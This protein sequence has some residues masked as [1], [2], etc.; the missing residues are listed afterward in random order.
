MPIL[1]H[2]GVVETMTAIPISSK[3]NRRSTPP[4]HRVQS[5]LRIVSVLIS[6][7]F[8]LLGALKCLPAT[9]HPSSAGCANL[10]PRTALAGAAPLRERGLC[11]AQ[12]SLATC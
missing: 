9:L 12:Y 10:T 6:S 8:K 4:E 2:H 11:C 1:I 3:K 7:G 5:R